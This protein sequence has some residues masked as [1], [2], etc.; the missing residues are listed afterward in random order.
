MKRLTRKI[1]GANNYCEFELKDQPYKSFLDIKRNSDLEW[2]D[3]CDLTLAIDK[4]GQLEDIEKELG[5]DLIT[6]FKALKQDYIYFK[7]Y[8]SWNKEFKIKKECISGFKYADNN[9]F[10]FWTD[11][12]YG[13]EHM[14][15][16]RDYGKA[17]ALREEDL[18]D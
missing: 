15:Y 13:K 12:Y 17:W 18:D 1:K 14:V 10:V 5:I 6:L 3:V 2:L 8:L 16:L 4:L 7:Y 11:D 9:T